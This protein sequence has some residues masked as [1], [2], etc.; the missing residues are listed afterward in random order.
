VTEP[1]P[2]EGDE[3]DEVAAGPT[4]ALAA[5]PPARPA[6]NQPRFLGMI[7]V[8]HAALWRGYVEGDE[9]CEI[10]GIGPI[11]VPSARRLLSDAVLYLLVTKGSAVGTTVNLKRGATVAQRVALLWGNPKCCVTGCNNPRT[12]IDH[13]EPWSETR[14]TKLASL[15]GLCGHHHDLKTRL[16]WRTVKENGITRMVP[17]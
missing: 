9:L 7:R 2:C 12:E 6:R 16:G 1:E 15:Q 4:D 11:P 17:P 10:A 14:V 13:V 8:D 3:A 5:C